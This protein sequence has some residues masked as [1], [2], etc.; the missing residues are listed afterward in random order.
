MIRRIG[1]VAALLFLLVTL[2]PA[3]PEHAQSNNSNSQI[4]LSGTALPASPTHPCTPWG[5]WLWS[6]PPTNDAY[7]G[8]NGNGD[9]SMY[10]YA[11][12]K[13]E[14][15][16]DVSDVVLS[17]DSV[18]ESASGTYPDGTSVSCTLKAH[19]T[20]P[21]K[22]ILDSMRCTVTPPGQVCTATDIGIT[23]DISNG[24]K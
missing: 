3:S 9:G 14:A 12:H 24:T 15:H 21:G 13:A 5:M 10:F 8:N 4:I 7:G 16:A 18:S 22:G 23:V 2:F 1:L 6:Q 11:I 19:Q 20:S 17:G